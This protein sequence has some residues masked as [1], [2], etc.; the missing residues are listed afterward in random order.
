[1][2]RCE[3]KKTEAGISC[4]VVYTVGDNYLVLKIWQKP[5]EDNTLVEKDLEDVA[6]LIVDGTEHFIF[7]DGES[8]MEKA[9]WT[10][11]NLG[12]AIVGRVSQEEMVVIVESIYEG[13]INEKAT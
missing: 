3:A 9:V 7:Y 11:G 4:R 2:Q 5:D 8:G 6:R 12:C 1:M 13:V 10:R